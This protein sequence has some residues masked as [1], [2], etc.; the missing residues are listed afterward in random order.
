MLN[1]RTQERAGVDISRPGLNRVESLAFL[2]LPYLFAVGL[3]FASTPD[4]AFIDLRYA[5]NIIH[6][7]GFVFNPGQHVQGFTS[8]LELLVAV[9]IYLIPGGLALFKMKLASV[10][11]GA[12]AIRT[13][14]RLLADL[15]MPVWSQK[16]GALTMAISPVIAF[17]SSNGLETSL[18]M[19]LVIALVRRL[20]RAS[21]GRDYAVAG[22]LAGA[23]VLARPDALAVTALL[24][25]AAILVEKRRPLW[26]RVSWFA[27]SIVAVLSL[28]VFQLAYFGSVLPNTYYAKDLPLSRAIAGGY[29]YVS[30]LLQP[31]GIDS[32]SNSPNL[33]H[34]VALIEAVFVVVGLY[35]MVHL[36]PRFWY[37]VAPIVGQV[38]FVLK[39]GG[40]YMVGGRF[41]APVAIPF[42]A[43]EALG[44]VTLVGAGRRAVTDALP[45]VPVLFFSILLFATSLIPLAYVNAPSWNIRG[46]EDAP[47]LGSRRGA[48]QAPL[49]V[50]M[51][52]LL[53]CLPSGDLVATSEVGLIG[54]A[55][56]DLRLLDVRG[57][58][59]RQV[60]REAPSS[61]KRTWG[62]QDKT[63]YL[64]TSPVGRI[65]LRA[66]PNVI[67]EID[68]DPTSGV[69]GGQ[70]RL[71]RE[72]N[73]SSGTVAV[74]IPSTAA[75]LCDPHG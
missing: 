55:R 26:R 68:T 47:L 6:G 12:L 21:S 25:A 51:P 58:T 2:Y 20:V 31:V 74:Y 13:G 69:L 29:D 41:L 60:A 71:W 63:W 36:G 16:V 70:Y 4:D 40:D 18:E 23:A 34:V 14:S 11:F 30:S 1:L 7:Y 48:T 32:L 75:N 57:L 35:S 28:G 66:H 67:V 65:L 56:L 49:W 62:V 59:N 45:D 50:R 15:D 39:A 19:W 38:L 43:I 5:A 61:M 64:T 44:L 9:V 3:V 72:L 53:R 73:L 33:V 54:F 46:L 10:L 42:I 22:V 8:P 37:L 27:G 17:S 52:S 24:A